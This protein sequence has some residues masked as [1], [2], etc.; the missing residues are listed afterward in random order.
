MYQ[1]ILT[2]L[3]FIVKAVEKIVLLT[4][5]DTKLI[6]FDVIRTKYY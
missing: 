1:I 6:L 5:T 3:K 4:F 2:K